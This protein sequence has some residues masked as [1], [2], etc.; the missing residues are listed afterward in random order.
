MKNLVFLGWL[1]KLGIVEGI[2]TLLLFFVAMPLKHYADM[3]EAVRFAGSLHG[4]LFLT[5]LAMFLIGR[6]VI[7][8]PAKL[9]VGGIVGSVIPFGPFVTEIWLRRLAEGANPDLASGNQI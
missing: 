9:V 1:R 6:E 7:P 3:P 5:L 4:F 8:L 2:S